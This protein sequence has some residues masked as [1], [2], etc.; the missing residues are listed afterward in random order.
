MTQAAHDTDVLRLWCDASSQA[1]AVEAGLKA[2]GFHV[3]TVRSSVKEPRVS[4]NGTFIAGYASV[5]SVFGV[6]PRQSQPA[7]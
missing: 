2:R 1:S 7:T 6:H 3:V 4:F 5:F